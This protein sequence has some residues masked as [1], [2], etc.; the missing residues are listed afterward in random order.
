MR[1]TSLMLLTNFKTLQ[2]KV[3]QKGNILLL[4]GFIFRDTS[5]GI[6]KVQGEPTD[7]IGNCASTTAEM[8]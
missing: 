8:I 2:G 6:Y 7:F 3:M 4:T 5:K 1:L